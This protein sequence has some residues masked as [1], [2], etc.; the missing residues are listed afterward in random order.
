MHGGLVMA[1]QVASDETAIRRL[2]DRLVEGIRVKDLDGLKRIYAT[3]IVSFDVQPPLQHVGANAKLKNWED[4]FTV[5]QAPLEYEVRDLTITVGEDVA[6]AHSF[7]RLNGTL[8]NG[9]RGGT[10]VRF[11]ACFQKIGGE[12][13]IV[14]DHVSVPIDMASGK[15]LAHLEP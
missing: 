1:E 10:W 12:W 14:H 3:D 13:L 11:T 6:F 7:N 9:A 5:F 15:A 8:K 4:T 2:I